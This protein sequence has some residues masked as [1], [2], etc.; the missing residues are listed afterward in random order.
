MCLPYFFGENILHFDFEIPMRVFEKANAPSG[1]KRRIGGIASAETV[2]RQKELLLARGLDFSDFLK[3]GW[4]NDNHSKDTAGIVGYPTDHNFFRKGD[5]LPDGQIAQADGHWVEGYL[6]EGH[7][8]A[9]R[10]WQLGKAL[11]KTDR[12]LGFSVEGKIIKRGGLNKAGANVVAKAK[13][14]NVAV[15]NAPVNTAARMEILAKS[16]QAVEEIE[17]GLGMGTATGINPPPGPQT[18]EGA[19]QVITGQ[20]LEHDEKEDEKKKKKNRKLTKAE[21]WVKNKYPDASLAQIRRFLRVV[22]FLKT[23]EKL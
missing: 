3:N 20:S 18:G 10:I 12:R 21:N 2:D 7:P 8:P 15:T 11:A 16:L 1:Q 19:G 14:R 9:D 23:Q 6:L 13:V 5:V 17:K 22:R 4:F